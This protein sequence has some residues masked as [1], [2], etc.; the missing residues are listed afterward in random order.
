[1]NNRADVDPLFELGPEEQKRIDQYNKGV[2]WVSEDGEQRAVE[3][4]Q[5]EMFFAKKARE[6][7]DSGW[8]IAY[9]LLPI[10][11]ALHSL[12]NAVDCIG[13]VIP[14]EID[15]GI[16]DGGAN[17]LLGCAQGLD[18]IGTALKTMA[19]VM[20]ENGKEQE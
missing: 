7:K 17:Y 6:G 3:R 5:M 10:G 11:H 12:N 15:V 1:M 20:E 2:E 4:Q 16:K 8:A 9:A 19:R 13:S 18:E 14:S